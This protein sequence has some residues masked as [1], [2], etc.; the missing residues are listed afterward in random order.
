MNNVAS[1]TAGLT[2][3]GM[4]ALVGAA[5]RLD[6]Q[7]ASGSQSFTVQSAAPEV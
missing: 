3:G 5:S 2:G 6:I 1:N 4:V 7:T